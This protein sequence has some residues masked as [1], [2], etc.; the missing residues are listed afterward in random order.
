[1]D[2]SMEAAFTQTE[3]GITLH[4]GHPLF[5][6]IV[7]DYSRLEEP[8][9]KYGSPAAFLIGAVLACYSDSLSEALLARGAHYR[10]I[11]AKGRAVRS[12]DASGLMRIDALHVDVT[13]DMDEQYAAELEHCI[14]IVRDC[15]MSRSV[16][17]G[18]PVELEAHRAS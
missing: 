6:D 3:Q 12:R 8:S 2:G 13:V 5:G 15:M 14:R 17:A 1:M 4:T 7:G 10:S 9:Q 11:Q 16:M 18:F